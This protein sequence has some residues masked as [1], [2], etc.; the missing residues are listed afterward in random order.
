MDAD[1][2]LDPQHS[3]SRLVSILKVLKARNKPRNIFDAEFTLTTA[4]V[5]DPV[6]PEVPL[7][8][9]MVGA[10][11]CVL[12][13]SPSLHSLTS[14]CPSA[15]WSNR[16]DND[17]DDVDIWLEPEDSR[18][19]IVRTTDENGKSVIRAANLNKLV[20]VLS[21]FCSTPLISSLFSFHLYFTLSF[22]FI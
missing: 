19:N 14:F 9:H 21:S 3:V 15:D 17:E 8:D 2:P 5:P 7:V 13:L 22:E 11:R 20:Q 16:I 6:D 12:I 4:R 18:K 10:G 1:F